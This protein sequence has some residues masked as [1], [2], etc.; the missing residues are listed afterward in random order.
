MIVNPT[1]L[2]LT[3]AAFAISL[4]LEGKENSFISFKAGHKIWIKLYSTQQH[5]IYQ[6]YEISTSGILPQLLK[7]DFNITKINKQNLTLI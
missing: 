1:K 7:N 2:K 5:N 6:F 4:K 3:R